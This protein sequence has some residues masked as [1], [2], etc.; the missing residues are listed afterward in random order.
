MSARHRLHHCD[1]IPSDHVSLLLLRRQWSLGRLQPLLLR[2]LLLRRLFGVLSDGP[3][4]RVFEEDRLFL[5]RHILHG[6]FILDLL[7]EYAVYGFV[8]SLSGCG[9][10]VL[11]L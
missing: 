9:L 2:L 7:V 3:L 10:I 6:L 11:V 8:D 4:I 5:W 1:Q